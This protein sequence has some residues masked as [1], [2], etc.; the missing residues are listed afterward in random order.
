MNQ[1]NLEQG[2]D[3]WKL[4]RKKGIGS[5]DIGTVMGKNQYQTVKT[6]WLEKTGQKDPEDLSDNFF[7]KRG[8]QLEPIAREIFNERTNSIFT[9]ATFVHEEFPYMKFSADG[10]DF[11]KNEII[12]I[13]CMMS[14]NHEKAIK[15]NAPSESYY[16]QMQ[17]GLMI[18][19]AKVCHFVAYNPEYP[20]PIFTK[21]IEPDKSIFS[22]MQK[23]AHWFWKCV[24]EKLDPEVF[25]L[26]QYLAESEHENALH[27][28]SHD[29]Q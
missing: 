12:E 4:W 18:T 28:Q 21:I 24:E 13:K 29:A 10:I 20:E 2:S 23:A 27:G 16:L 3:Q 11:D 8:Q 5:S 25:T 7:V 9:P 17:W 1:I 14:K 15:D 26:A 6:L 22:D 19:G